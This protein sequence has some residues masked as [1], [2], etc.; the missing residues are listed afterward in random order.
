MLSHS[1]S[2]VLLAVIAAG[3]PLM[4]QQTGIT[5]RVTD[6]SAGLIATARI[7]A[8]GDDGTK[9]L[10]TTNAQGLYQLPA[11][12]AGM[13]V[14]RFEA[15]GFAPAERTLSLL[16]GQM[17][18]VD[19][20]LQVASASAVVSV[21]AEG[22]AVDT[23]SSSVAG[24]VSPVEVS[25]L[26]LNG[27]NYLQLAMMVPGITSNDVT[28]SP[29][30]ATDGGKLQINVDGQQVTQN[31]AGDSFG[32]PQ[33]SQDAI[34]QFQIITNRFDATLGR[35]S[36][37]QVNVQTKS[38]SNQFHGTLYGYFRNDAFNA[39]DSAAHRLLPFSDQQ[40]GG[41]VGGPIL[42]D[43]LLFFFAYEG[44]RQ[45]N[46]SVATPPGFG[47]LSYSFANELRTNSY[48]LHSDWLLSTNNHI[49]VRATGYTWQVPF[50]N[51]SGAVSP[52]RAT[53]STRTS[54]AVLATWNWTVT[55][56][57]VNELKGG[58][59]HFDWQNLPLISSQEYRLPT[60]T[61]G[62]PYNYPQQLGQNTSQFRD[63]LFWLKG[64][65]SFKAGG[66]Y[67]RT[68]YSGNFGQ[69]VRGTVLSFSSGVSSLNL[70]S[71]FPNYADPSTWNL[72]ALS[73]YATSYT[74]GFG[75]YI[76][77]VNTNSIGFW[78]QDDWKVSP[79][80]TLNLGVRYDNDLG[81]FNPN[82]TLKSGVQTP[83]YN[84]NLLFQP[85]L[86]FAWDVTGSRKTVIRGGAGL[87]YA[88]IQ[89][90]AT[91]DDAIFNG[92]TTISPTVTG[93]ATNPVN[94]S[95]PFGTVTGP[96]FLSGAVPVTAQTIQPLGPNVHTPYSLQLSGGV[97]HQLTKTW[98][99]SADF[100]H[101]RV[102][103]D[104][105]RTDANVFY[106]PATGYL[107]NP[108]LGRPNPAF[109]GILNF[110]TPAA[111]GSIYNALQVSVQHRFSQSFSASA[112]YTLSHLKDSTTSPFYY[113]NNQM[114]LASEWATSPDNQ[115]NTLTLAG[116]YTWKYGFAIS[117]S[118][119]YGSGQN[120]GVTANQ[121]PFNATGVTNRLFL[122]TAAYYGSP[123]NI[124]PETINGV[125]YNLVKRDSLVGNP[126]ER[127]D[128]RLSKTFTIKE[129]F[130]LIPMVEAF[131]LFNHSNFGSYTTVVN[132][133]AYGAPAQNSD[134]AY[135]ARMLQFAGRFEF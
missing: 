63:D 133:A 37:I 42:K 62:A 110:V 54:Y 36:R 112:A 106:N 10:T 107:A 2:R 98:S 53:D 43:K 132:L 5:G 19:V 127:V 22:A 64:G 89:A 58:L 25:R 32:E 122:A 134:L 11:L 24:D 80:L 76:Y 46:T 128:L 84:D 124:T 57:V 92:Q 60:V 31:S 79:R 135:A 67:L 30:G 66:E 45:P 48:L 4:A 113:P 1:F 102:Y 33:Y 129:H 17:A 123:S 35:S 59:N 82:L 49:S 121:N 111:A 44:E 99:L 70:A 108:S 77:S 52:T 97:E 100:V 51:V 18:N 115:T 116:S 41:T 56:S 14:V 114:D 74:Q 47:G 69:N 3:V 130:R 34:D 83:H 12:R 21:E 101:F 13:Y 91:I 15:S 29:L 75:N 71:I 93:T 81:I 38:G 65:H 39:D 109:A 28:N 68:P 8:T 104:W 20:A 95:A 96:Q 27:R 50:N 73:P 61:I 103:H 55:P 40:F 90:N 16:V 118:F 131:N 85:R 72:A 9:L 88:D 26:P 6:P 87:F 105:E 117:G 86:G 23:T 94:L 78:M 126:I 120:F 125:A 119:H 7:T